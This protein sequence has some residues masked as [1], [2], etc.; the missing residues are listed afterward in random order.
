MERWTVTS[1]SHFETAYIYHEVGP[2]YLF[3]IEWLTMTIC[4]WIPPIPFPKWK[5]TNQ[6]LLGDDYINEETNLKDWYG[7][8]RNF[9]HLKIDNRILQWVWKKFKVES[10]E[11][12]YKE[13][14][15][16]FPE[17]IDQDLE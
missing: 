5:I 6:S 1:N 15:E 3:F 14:I 4:D 12:D 10:L 16:K 8:L 9:W 17:E 7:N 13:V 2:W 11:I